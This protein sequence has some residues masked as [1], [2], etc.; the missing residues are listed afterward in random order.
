[1]SECTVIKPRLGL[2]DP[3]K[4]IFKTTLFLSLMTYTIHSKLLWLSIYGKIGIT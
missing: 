2:V 4:N 1:M 3:T